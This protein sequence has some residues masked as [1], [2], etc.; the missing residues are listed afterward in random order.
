MDNPISFI[1]AIK[2]DY[3]YFFYK[4]IPDFPTCCVQSSEVLGG[5]I[6]KRFNTGIIYYGYYE[7]MNHAWLAIDGKVIDFT[8]FQFEYTKELPK[9]LTKDGLFSLMQKYQG[10]IQIPKKCMRDYEPRMIV[11]S[12]FTRYYQEDF[13]KYLEKVAML[14]I[15]KKYDYSKIKS[16]PVIY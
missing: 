15:F 2:K 7:D 11:S 9:N 13:S 10:D 16:K 8:L 5:Y 3:L 1:T 12:R 6:K 4:N 14:Q